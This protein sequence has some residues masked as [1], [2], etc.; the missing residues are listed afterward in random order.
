MSDVTDPVATARH[1]LDPSR[2]AEPGSTLRATAVFVLGN[3]AEL[4]PG[5]P[6][7]GQHF[8]VV[9]AF[10]TSSPAGQ[11]ADAHVD[12]LDRDGVAEYLSQGAEFLVMAGPQPIAQARITS[13]FLK[14]GA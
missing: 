6:A 8:S 4:I 1:W 14:P 3:D 12:I 11:E 7:T 2:H 9:F 13:V 10:A 5:W